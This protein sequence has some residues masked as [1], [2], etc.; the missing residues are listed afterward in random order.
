MT[1][2]PVRDELSP[3]GRTLVQW[4]ESDGRM[5]HVIRTPTILDAAG[6]ETILRCGDSGYDASIAWGED[7][8]FDID[9]R[10][11]WR[12]ETLRLEVDRAR[13]SFRA[14][15]VG[16]DGP[17]HPLGALSAFV[18]AHFTGADGERAAAGEAA[19]QAQAERLARE[20]RSGARVLWIM[21]ALGAGA[22]MW[23]LFF[24]R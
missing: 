15:G 14:S 22:A 13:D 17:P 5:S 16:G 23:A 24:R 10:H 12:P 2:A 3:D 6:G 18:E 1:C 20:R 9:L 21:V 19:G 8:G 7:S 11:Y 4:S